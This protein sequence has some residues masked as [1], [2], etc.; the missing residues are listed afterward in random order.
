[1]IFRRY[2]AMAMVLLLPL[3]L[4][5]QDKEADDS[6]GFGFAMG[7]GIGTTSI[8]DPQ[9]GEPTAWNNLSL[10]PELSIGKFGMG[11]AVDIN[12]A[13]TNGKGESGFRI[14]KE[15]WIPGEQYNFWELYLP[16]FRYIRYGYKGEPFF[17]KIG[18]VD[19]FRLGNG[20]IISN[21]AN[22]R[23]LPDQRITGLAF[24]LD[25]RLFGFPYIGFETLVGNI[26]NWDVMG[27]RFYTRPIYW[28]QIPVI[29]ELQFGFTAVADR[30]PYYFADKR[31][32][33]ESYTQ[34]ET[35]K[36]KVKDVVIWGLDLKLPIVNSKFISL[37]LFGDMAKQKDNYGY[38]AGFGGS[39]LNLITYGAQ[40]R[41]MDKNF[42]PTY[43]DM[44]YDLFRM[45][46]W[47]VYSEEIDLDAHKGW[48]ANLGI[49]ALEGKL[50]F[51]TMLEGSFTPD[52]GNKHSLPILTGILHMEKGLLG[53]FSFEALYQK[54]YIEKLSDLVSP[55]NALIQ[56]TIGYSSG[57]ATISMIY[58]LKYNP[59]DSGDDWEITSKLEASISLTQ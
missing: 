41:F 57:A 37:A 27:G 29:K 28:L 42:Q 36:D 35:Y 6:G 5:A 59:T 7:L 38:M 8:D 53:G 12:F 43:F 40:F 26:A 54:K 24:D 48:M 16:I 58:D 52:V 34:Y 3:L 25:G 39:L 47:L 31:P 49:D 55:Q 10:R 45:E 23:Y 15:D 13:F 4:S 22:T 19:D 17:A 51:S 2:T 21:Y 30:N 33:S 46:K 56:A 1:M 14:R 50:V 18:A 11:L 9:T 20:F 32:D 44:S